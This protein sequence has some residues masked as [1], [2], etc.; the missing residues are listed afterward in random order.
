[1]LPMQPSLRRSRP[2]RGRDREIRVCCAI[3]QSSGGTNPVPL[4]LHGACESVSWLRQPLLIACAASLIAACAAIPPP[5]VQLHWAGIFSTGN[6]WERT[7]PAA[8]TERSLHSDNFLLERET[9][10]VTATA[11]T[12]FGIAYTFL[13][14]FDPSERV[15]H[16]VV[17]THPDGHS[18]TTTQT[19]RVEVMCF[20]GRTIAGLARAQAQGQW[21]V[22]VWVRQERLIRQSFDVSVP[23]REPNVA[24]AMPSAAR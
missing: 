7:D 22:E 23:N 16:R 12:I 10:S 5:L 24:K 15:E 1:M 18:V 19:C 13:Q 8:P 4:S 14:G 9:T 6:A 11:G 3:D 20:T 21:V 17:W 2:R